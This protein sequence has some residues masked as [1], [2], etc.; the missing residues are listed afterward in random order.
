M[1]VFSMIFLPVTLERHCPITQS[2]HQGTHGWV[3]RLVHVGMF[4]AVG[5]VV[6]HR[7]AQPLSKAPV[8]RPAMGEG[9]MYGEIAWRF[10]SPRGRFCGYPPGK[11]PLNR[12]SL[13]LGASC[14][15][16]G[17]NSQW[18]GAL[19]PQ[20]GPTNHSQAPVYHHQHP[21]QA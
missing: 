18:Y 20:P 8:E 19:D 13:L 5:Q 15:P 9:A 2:H 7:E 17:V 10:T 11:T 16:L 6:Q 12:T 14:S 3:R 4:A 21:L 1:C